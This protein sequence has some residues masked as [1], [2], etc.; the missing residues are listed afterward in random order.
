MKD[1][2]IT[3]VPFFALYV[4]IVDDLLKSG[5]GDALIY[6]EVCSVSTRLGNN[7]KSHFVTVFT[8]L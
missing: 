2:D 8:L 5:H 7:N 6:Q 4:E 1:A 3:S